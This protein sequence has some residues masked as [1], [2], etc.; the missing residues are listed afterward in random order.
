VV[1]ALG[2][3]LARLPLT[4]PIEGQRFLEGWALMRLVSDAKTMARHGAGLLALEALMPA[5]TIVQTQ[6]LSAVASP[7]PAE[8]SATDGPDDFD[9]L[10]E[11]PAVNTLASASDLTSTPAPAAPAP[12]ASSEPLPNQDFWF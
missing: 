7:V 11:A 2:Q 4:G 3:W 8:A 1:Q 9:A 6:G 10:F 5:D 12:A